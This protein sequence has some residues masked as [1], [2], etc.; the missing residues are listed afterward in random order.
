MTLTLKV[1]NNASRT[2][3]RYNFRPKMH[4]VFYTRLKHKTDNETY[5]AKKK[6]LSCRHKNYIFQDNKRP[7]DWILR[8]R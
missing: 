2:L 8:G 3:S 4:C 5:R 6:L 7:Q 1:A